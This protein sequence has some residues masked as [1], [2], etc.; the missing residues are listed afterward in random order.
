MREMA[1]FWLIVPEARLV[2]IL[3]ST[4]I[5]LC[6]G[7]S[8]E[9]RIFDTLD[10]FKLLRCARTHRGADEKPTSVWDGRSTEGCWL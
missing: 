7:P 9:A 10:Y 1:T 5:M 4:G 3:S 2:T 8:V 6:A